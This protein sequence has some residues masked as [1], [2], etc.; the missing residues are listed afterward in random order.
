[1]KKLVFLLLSLFV[2]SSAWAMN[3]ADFLNKIP[4]NFT[5]ECYEYYSKIDKS[6][7]WNNQTDEKYQTYKINI[8]KPDDLVISQFW[9]ILPYKFYWNS[10]NIYNYENNLW[11][12][13]K[14]LLDYNYNTFKEINSKTQNEL[15]LRFEDPLEKDDF[16]FVFNYHANNYKASFYISDDKISWDLIKRQDLEDFSFKYLKIKFDSKTNNIYLENIKIYELNFVKKSNTILVKSFYNDDIEIY[17]N[18]NCKQKDF[19]TKA[20]AYDNFSIDNNTRIINLN[21]EN[22]PKYNV[23]TKKDLDNDWVEDSVD[24]CKTRYNPNQ[25]DSN[26]DGRGD[27]CMDDDK[28]W[29]IGYYDNCIYIS[30]KDQKDINNNWVWDVCEFDKDED[31]IFDSKDNCIIKSNP[32]Q[33]DQDKDWIGDICDNCE[34]YNPSQ[35]DKDLNWIWDVCDDRLKKL[36][37]NDDDKDLVINNRD[38][39]RYIANPDQKDSDKDWIWDVC[40]NCIDIDNKKQLDLDE[41]W[42]W[43]LCEDSDDDW[44]LWYLDNCIN[45]TNK[46]Q[47]DDDNDWIW[48][49]CEDDDWDWVLFALDNCPYNYNS[50]QSD[51]DNDN[52]WDKCDDKDDRYIE[53]NKWFFIWLLV[54]ITFLF[55]TGIFYMIRKL[56]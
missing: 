29:I 33:K 56:K 37:Q 55:G 9:F 12:D 15:I 21:L 17:S 14:Y 54:F 22:N 51:I 34:Y 42:I 28:D 46:G 31:W 26:W 49:L 41:N 4:D 27:I 50:D 40:D 3:P 45:I 2:F 10:E 47:L 23:Y 32:E 44:Y 30:N 39:C 20:L 25:K 35:I 53:S 52:I 38:N 13:N 16:S 24:N 18:F 1:M 7:V 5:S 8:D 19:S 48:N 11:I 43:D 36:E 6:E